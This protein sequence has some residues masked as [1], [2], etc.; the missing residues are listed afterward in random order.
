MKTR[1]TFQ[2]VLALLFTLS[3][4]TMVHAASSDYEEVSYEDLLKELDQKKNQMRSSIRT[5][6]SLDAVKMHVGVGFANS[7]T[8]ISADKSNFNRHASG[9]QVSLGMDLMTPEW[10]T[11]GV[12]RNYG[13]NTSGNEELSLKELELKLGYT[14]YLEGI[15]KYSLSAGIS[16]RFMKFSD[17]TRGISVNDTTPSLV[18]GTGFNAQINRFI[19]L[20]AEVSA[21]T[22]LVD[23]TAD[24]N[25]FDLIFKLNTTL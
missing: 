17:D 11:E 3:A 22:A 4:G 9:V 16:N 13:V 1:N 10:F 25:S 14:N 2:F 24:K 5:N 19:S 21:R 6:D 23:R 18:V 7:F 8:N 12:F 20:G 15:W